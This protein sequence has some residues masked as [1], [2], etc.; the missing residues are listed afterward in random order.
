[1]LLQSFAGTEK[2]VEQFVS[3]NFP[4]PW[5]SELLFQ[6]IDSRICKR[7]MVWHPDGRRS[8]GRPRR[9]FQT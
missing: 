4:V 2:D 3:S 7:I 9:R 8:K 1:M 5:L 6:T